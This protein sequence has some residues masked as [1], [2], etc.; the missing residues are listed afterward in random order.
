MK[1]IQNFPFSFLREDKLSLV[2]F[3]VIAILST[4]VFWFNHTYWHYPPVNYFANG[5]VGIFFFL[6]FSSLGAYF[7]VG[8]SA[9]VTQAFFY[10]L[11]Y[12]LIICLSMYATTAVQL[13][14]FKPIDSLLLPIDQFFHYDM[15]KTLAFLSEYAWIRKILSNV[16]NFALFELLIVPIF[17]MVRG[18]FYCV[19]QYFCLLLL[20]TLMGFSFYFFWPTTAPASVLKSLYF[21]PEQHNTGFKFY[22]IH[23]HIKATLE[24]GGL[25]AMPSFHMIWSMLCQYSIRR[26]QWLW[27]GLLPMNILVILASIFLG[28]HYFSDFLGSLLVIFTAYTCSRAWSNNNLFQNTMELSPPLLKRG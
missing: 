23:H 24:S 1:N 20:S 15:V 2:T 7:L 5:I 9:R 6:L 26:I 27:Y 17:L 28:W 10:M 3:F 22:Q 8:L 14:P 4:I 12:H 11:I 18:E 13:T 25:I 16:Y 19:K 21:L